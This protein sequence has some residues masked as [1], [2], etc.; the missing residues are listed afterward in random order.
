MLATINWP[1]LC[2]GLCASTRG[3]FQ[4]NILD[5]RLTPMVLFL[6]LNGCKLTAPE[7][8]AAIAF[9]NLAAGKLTEAKLAAW[10]KEHCSK[11]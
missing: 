5:Q 6:E 2:V 4:F 7:A 1:F 9:E 3:Y 11:A 8:A 10:F